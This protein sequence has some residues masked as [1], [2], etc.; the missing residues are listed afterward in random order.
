MGKEETSNI[1]V[2]NLDISRVL[3]NIDVSIHRR[4]YFQLYLSSESIVL[5]QY[6]S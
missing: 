2:E 5:A 4:C 1:D 3:E 6:P